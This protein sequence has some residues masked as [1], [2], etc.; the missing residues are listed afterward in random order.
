MS[1][2]R[3]VHICNNMLTNTIFSGFPSFAMIMT[4][5]YRKGGTVP[6]FAEIVERLMKNNEK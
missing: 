2:V 1:D 4:D 6:G 5:K 3:F